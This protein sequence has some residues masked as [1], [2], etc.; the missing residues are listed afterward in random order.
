MS[1]EIQQKSIKKARIF[2]KSTPEEKKELCSGRH[3][4]YNYGYPCSNDK[5]GYRIIRKPIKEDW[6]M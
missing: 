4:V 6:M 5:S 3:S 2:R 1:I